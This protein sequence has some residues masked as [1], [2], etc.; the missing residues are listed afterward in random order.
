VGAVERSLDDAV[1][2]VTFVRN[3]LYK[4]TNVTGPSWACRIVVAEVTARAERFA[5]RPKHV[6]PPPRVTAAPASAAPA[7]RAFTL[8]G[9]GEAPQAPEPATA[10]VAAPHAPPARPDRGYGRCADRE[11]GR[12]IESYRY[13]LCDICDAAWDKLARA[14]GLIP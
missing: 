4:V 11:C 8:V 2:A 9:A 10:R 12:P 1:A 13:G 6:A 7:P 5:R 3:D 14:K